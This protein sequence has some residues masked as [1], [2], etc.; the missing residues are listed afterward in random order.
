MCCYPVKQCH[1]NWLPSSKTQLKLWRQMDRSPSAW[2]CGVLAE[3]S[4]PISFCV[5]GS[6][7]QGTHIFFFF[8]LLFF[9]PPS[10][11][12]PLRDKIWV[13]SV[14]SLLHLLKS[15]DMNAV[16]RLTPALISFT[17]LSFQQNHSIL[18]LVTCL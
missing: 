11:P 13:T 9:P 18:Y 1:L 10:P 16:L 3:V 7:K 17:R 14:I 15:T 12:S 6:D 4:K 2:K 5:Q 8:F